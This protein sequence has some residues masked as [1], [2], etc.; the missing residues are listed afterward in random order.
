VRSAHDDQ[1]ARTVAFALRVRV[2]SWT[3]RGGSAR[4]NGK[5]LDGFAAPGGYLVLTQA[6]VVPARAH[7]P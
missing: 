2:P 5:P 6:R 7:Q 3:A 4:L 1:A